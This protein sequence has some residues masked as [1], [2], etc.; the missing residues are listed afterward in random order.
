MNYIDFI[1]SP[2][3]RDHLRTLPPLPPAQRCILIAQSQIRPLA[4]KLDAL[5]EIREATPP[6]DFASLTG[7]GLFSEAY[8]CQMYLRSYSRALM[9]SMLSCFSMPQIIPFIAALR[10]GQSA[11][12]FMSSRKNVKGSPSF[13]TVKPKPVLI[14]ERSSP[15]SGMR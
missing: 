2:A 10:T 11:T 15:S 8:G 6:E 4:D 14:V 1:D 5:R 13:A 7:G 3:V 9:K 12:N